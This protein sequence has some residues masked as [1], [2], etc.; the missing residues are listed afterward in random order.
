MNDLGPTA[1]I[2]APGGVLLAYQ[3]NP[4]PGDP[5]KPSFVRSYQEGITGANPA[6]VFHDSGAM[7]SLIEEAGLEIV[8]EVDHSYPHTIPQ[9]TFPRFIGTYGAIAMLD[10]PERQAALADAERLAA[11]DLNGGT[12]L[13]H[14][15][16]GYVA[17][18]PGR[19]GRVIL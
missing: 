10:E 13:P 2:L 8:K 9:G 5:E 1:R 16:V 15:V 18:N 6:Q 12:Q 7:R 19:R 17:V 3:N 11:E 4:D 14:R